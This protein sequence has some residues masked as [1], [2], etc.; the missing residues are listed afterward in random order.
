MKTMTWIIISVVLLTNS[1]WG[2]DLDSG[3]IFR[4]DFTKETKLEFRGKPKTVNGVLVLDGQRDYA[5]VPNSRGMHLTDKGMTYVATV[6]LNC[7]EKEHM[8]NNSYDMFISKDKEFIFGKWHTG[9]LYVNFHDGTRWCA[10]TKGGNTVPFG[11]WVHV[12]AVIEHFNDITQ[13][14]V[15]YKISLYI[16]GEREYSQRFL[17]IVPGAKDSPVLIGNGFSGGP[18]FMN[19][20][21]A[22]VAMYN[23]PLSSSE[24][25]KLCSMEKRVK[26]L[27]GG[28]GEIEPALKALTQQIE[29]TGKAPARWAA[30]AIIRAASAK[31]EQK[32]LYPLAETVLKYKNLDMESFSEAINSAQ[33]HAHII[34]TNDL[35]A[36]I[37]I[38]KGLGAHPIIGVM[39][40]KNGCE[41][42]GEKT[43]GWE[44]CRH[45]DGMTNKT[46]NISSGV[47]WN[48][49]VVGNTLKIK[50][51][52]AGDLG[53]TAE[54]DV[55]FNGSRIESSFQIA[56]NSKKYIID[57][58]KYP[59]YSFRGLGKGD[60]LVH[61]YRSGLLIANPT[62]EQFRYGQNGFYPTF[63]VTMQF[64][65]YYD[66]SRQGIYFGCEDPLGRVKEYSAEGKRNNL[67]ISWS[68]PVAQAPGNNNFQL[69]GK[70]AL[71]LYQ[72]E[73]YEAGQIYRRFLE[74]KAVW[75]IPELPRKSTP[76]WF[77]NNTLWIQIYTLSHNQAED[78]RNTL[79]YLRSYFGLPF[80]VN[81]Y[82]WNDMKKAGWPHF[83]AQDYTKEI[84]RQIQDCGIY[85]FPY[86]DSR[87]WQLKD[88]HGAK[89]WMFTSHGLKY[90]VKKEDGSLW[91]EN[92]GGTQY[93]VMC[94][95]VTGW[96]DF[97]SDL[98][99][100]LVT[101]YKFNGIY[102]DQVAASNPR[103]CFDRTHKHPFNDSRAWIENGYWKLFERM[104]QKLHKI[105]RNICHT[106][107]ESAEPYLKQFDGY[108]VW[109]WT[110]NGQIPL[111][112]SIYAGRAQFVGR[113]F[114]RERRGDPQSF[115]SKIGQ[116]LVNAEQIGRFM[117]DEIKE[118]D[119]RRL[120]TKK[121][122]HVRRA[123]LYWFNEGL[124]LSPID[125]GNTMKQEF[126]LWGAYQ[127]VIVKMPC[128]ANSAWQGKDGSRVWLFVNT[129][130]K[131]AS[132]KPVVSSQKGWWICKEGAQ[133][134]VFSKVPCEVRLPALGYE[135]WIEG[136][137]TQ[138]DE[139]QKT[140]KNISTFDCGKP[141]HLVMKFA[142]KR[143]KGVPGKKYTGEDMAGSA[144][145]T[146]YPDK[147][148][149]GW[150]NDG[151]VISFGE[152]DFGSAGATTVTVSVGVSPLYAGG[153][154]NLLTTLP[155]QEE[156]VAAVIPLKSTGGFQVIQELTVP[157]HFK[158]T[159]KHNIIFKING[160]AACEFYGWCYR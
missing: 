52:G 155:G 137:R 139:I 119:T 59:I 140:L 25:A 9:H 34:L 8:E 19:G 36:F 160:N 148:R 60:R 47:S 153:S 56:N 75:W 105:D 129:Q 123:L 3:L 127:P 106:S 132:A 4:Y 67:E 42:F 85:T 20:E 91:I 146:L 145:C 142:Q 1:L 17:Q 151:A 144:F 122:V 45:K 12:A 109:G 102:H 15:G 80:C 87:L 90:A 62:E 103:M 70:A 99:I 43:F 6:K 149:F 130:S 111:Y 39:N 138:A 29:S 135:I 37:L 124:M 68:H 32:H 113:L 44:F 31:A 30:A 21:M 5:V 110:E 71:E 53:F 97:L 63:S 143:I 104:F 49:A 125:F 152:V 65:A 57:S 24:I 86:I 101:E 95:A 72:G 84:N 50:W 22:N 158:L 46:D 61:P 116:Q 83:P 73:W 41:I 2:Q 64:G 154:I 147:K 88:G 89:D 141:M 11:E 40:R 66:A 120:F 126:S 10:K 69:S 74:K 112:Q 117:L 159:G 108:V 26:N 118:A 18:W 131:P 115:F 58:V 98:V 82:R 94:P 92:Y 38:G 48:S 136:T 133:K 134:P 81:W 107:E 121:A 156:K 93:A 35:A 128:I 54:S 51:A 96:Q 78:V 28:L 23:R 14:E 150:I 79:T 77:R 114:D 100:R 76:E 16:N 13:A 157:L 55:I 7:S 27:R 33:K